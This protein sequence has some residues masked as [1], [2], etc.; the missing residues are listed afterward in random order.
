M[1]DL[2]NQTK[3]SV[4]PKALFEHWISDELNKNL[5]ID[6]SSYRGLPLYKGEFKVVNYLVEVDIV[7]AN[8]IHKLNK[9][10]RHIDKP[11]DVLSFPIYNKIP[12]D[13][14]ENSR[15]KLSDISPQTIKLLGII[16]I[17][18]EIAKQQ[19][20][21]NNRSVQNE[22]ESLTNHSLRHLIG[23]HHS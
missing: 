7:S 22:L 3:H 21:E 6:K 8:E 1:V 23:I 2:I 11:T 13:R 4:P 18:Y 17:C 20:K 16:V 10:Y 19:A 12:F 15:S 5:P 9:K 14:S